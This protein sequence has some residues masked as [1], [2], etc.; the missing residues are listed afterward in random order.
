M[1]GCGSDSTKNLGLLGIIF[2]SDA[3]AQKLTFNF[4][5]ENDLAPELVLEFYKMFA[6]FAQEAVPPHSKNI[7]FNKDPVNNLAFQWE[8]RVASLPEP[9]IVFQ[10]ME[11]LFCLVD[12]IPPMLLNDISLVRGDAAEIIAAGNLPTVVLSTCATKVEKITLEALKNIE[13]LNLTIFGCRLNRGIDAVIAI[14]FSK[15]FKEPSGAT[16]IDINFRCDPGKGVAVLERVGRAVTELDGLWQF[17]E[18]YFCPEFWSVVTCKPVIM[19]YWYDKAVEIS[20]HINS[21]NELMRLKDEAW[22]KDSLKPGAH[23]TMRHPEIIKDSNPFTRIAYAEFF[24]CDLPIIICRVYD[25]LFVNHAAPWVDLVDYVVLRPTK[26]AQ[27]N[28]GSQTFEII[29]AFRQGPEIDNISLQYAKT[30][31]RIISEL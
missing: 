13:M 31:F 18:K 5:F 24:K 20:Y 8:L 22:A 26:D 2:E 28:T 12:L 21:L 3:A 17:S 4:V 11:L 6:H 19:E 10:N 27:V 23:I 30:S 14:D 29:V 9:L 16:T 15:L 1:L 7:T 25:M